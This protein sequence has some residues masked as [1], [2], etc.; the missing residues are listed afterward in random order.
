MFITLYKYKDQNIMI[1]H[2]LIRFIFMIYYLYWYFSQSVI[3]EDSVDLECIRSA[4]LDLQLIVDSSGSVGE[5]DFRLLM[6]VTTR[7]RQN[8]EIHWTLKDQAG[9]EICFWDFIKLVTS[10]D[11]IFLSYFCINVEFQ[12]VR[13][14]W[15]VLRIVIVS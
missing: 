7:P 1:Q 14:V 11:M 9:S 12:Y 3:I 8:F 10:L 6:Q 13:K 5:K 4:K 2:F 15:I